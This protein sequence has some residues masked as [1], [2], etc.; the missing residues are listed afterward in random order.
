MWL[1]L[2]L[3]FGGRA[4]QAVVATRKQLQSVLLS[5]CVLRKSSFLILSP[6]T[7]QL[8]HMVTRRSSRRAVAR[9]HSGSSVNASRLV[10]WLAA[11]GITHF[12]LR[13]RTAKICLSTTMPTK[14]SSIDSSGKWCCV[15]KLISTV[16]F[17][18]SSILLQ[19]WAA[20][21]HAPI[22]WSTSAWLLIT[23]EN[24]F[25]GVLTSLRHCKILQRCFYDFI[26][27]QW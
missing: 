21:A 17:L 23:F 15:L 12:R 6:T 20:V 19:V 9:T 22:T 18:L 13:V 5:W 10:S 8:L 11:F 7:I 25:A 1:F 27:W 3:D 16:V 26:L 2:L 24:D 14:S 4:L